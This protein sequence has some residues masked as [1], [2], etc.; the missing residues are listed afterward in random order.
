M[1]RPG[2]DRPNDVNYNTI[3]MMMIADNALTLK[4]IYFHVTSQIT[5]N[6][7]DWY[8]VHALETCSNKLCKTYWQDGAAAATDLMS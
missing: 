8:V 6:V 1:F 2:S 7:D 5:A 3:S 4:K